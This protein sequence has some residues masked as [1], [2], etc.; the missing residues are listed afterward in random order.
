MANEK[1]QIDYKAVLK[2]KIPKNDNVMGLSWEQYELTD[3]NYRFHKGMKQNGEVCTGLKGGVFTASIIGTPSMEILAWIFDHVK[4]FNGEIT[5][6]DPSEENIEQVYFEQARLT[7][8]QL[9]YKAGNT[10]HTVT[11]LTMVVDSLQID[12]AYFENINQ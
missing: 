3:C 4:K 6:M 1:K 12:N 11:L 10:P 2:L 7:G 5:V 8:L 9:Q